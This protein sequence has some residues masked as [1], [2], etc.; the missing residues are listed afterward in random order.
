MNAKLKEYLEKEFGSRV[1]FRRTERKLYGHDIAA[2]PGLV[3][4]FI[5]S[6]VPEGGGPAGR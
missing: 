4:R 1:N 6:T 2:V 5:G 3:R